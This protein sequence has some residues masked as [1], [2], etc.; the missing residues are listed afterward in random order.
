MGEVAKGGQTIVFASH[1]MVAIERLCQRCLVI[2]RGRIVAD[3]APGDANRTY[4]TKNQVGSTAWYRKQPSDADAYFTEISLRDESG[5]PIRFITTTTDPVLTVEYRM[6][7]V[8]PQVFLS[9][10]LFDHFRN[11]IFGSEPV[12]CGAE[13]PLE[14]GTYRWQ[15]RFPKHLLVEKN[16]GISVARWEQHLGT[17][18]KIQEIAFP[19]ETGDRFA[20]RNLAGLPCILGL[21]CRWTLV[22]RT[23][24][25]NDEGFSVWWFTAN[26]TVAD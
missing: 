25:T 13:L 1:N 3:A 8:R 26:R 21:R 7:R 14:P 2:D 20:T 6:A 24:A 5:S 11:Q 19:V 18:D 12:D 17:I 22:S 9:A 23:D 16:D 4:L 10:G 15:I